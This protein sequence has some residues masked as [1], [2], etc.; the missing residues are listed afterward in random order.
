MQNS[1]YYFFLLEEEILFQNMLKSW[2]K[3]LQKRLFMRSPHGSLKIMLRE[4][5]NKTK[6]KETEKIANK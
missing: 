1:F 2:Q 5:K 4:K 6:K 3:S